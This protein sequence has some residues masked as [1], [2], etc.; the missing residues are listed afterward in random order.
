MPLF[1]LAAIEKN[2]I[3]EEVMVVAPE[4]ILAKDSVAAEIVFLLDNA[5]LIRSKRNLDKGWELKV[6]YY[7]FA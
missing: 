3:G 7:P 4:W 5:E 2:S 1:L 6:L